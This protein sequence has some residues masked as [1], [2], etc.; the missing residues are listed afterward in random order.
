MTESEQAESVERG[1]TSAETLN[2]EPEPIDVS[3]RVDE[4]IPEG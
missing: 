2:V 4:N 1:E 3:V